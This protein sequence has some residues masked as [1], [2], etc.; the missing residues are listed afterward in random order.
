MPPLHINI[1]TSDYD[2]IRDIALGRVPIE[3][4]SIN[5][6]IYPIEETFYRFVHYREWDVS[7]MSF[8]KFA[9]IMSE[10]DPDI[11]GL[12]IFTARM[13]RQS[14]VYV[15]RGGG[16]ESGADLAGKRI[17]V[18]EWAQTAA[19]YTRGWLTDDLGIPLSD[20]Q[21]FQA[22][23]NEPGRREQISLSLPEGCNLTPVPDKSLKDMLQDG[24]LDAIFA[25][26]PPVGMDAPDCLIEP[27]FKDAPAE[28]AAY[29]EASGIFPI[30]HIMAIRRDVYEA[31][32]WLAQNL[33]KAFTQARE[34]SLARIF[35]RQTSRFM[36]PWIVEYA[37]Q[38]KAQLGK[39]YYPYGLE[40]N[41]HTLEVYLRWCFEQGIC[42]R[43]LT[44]DELFA[45][46][47]RTRFKV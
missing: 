2:H 23:L 33:L 31:N 8:G 19:I 25:A 38:K 4:A 47:T 1:A 34:M 39:D 20:V 29:F 13:F 17:G 30:M 10:D 9:S 37:E 15:R 28:E 46:E 18:P 11:I 3:G 32:R 7:E 35:D 21:W 5:Y 14:S 40:E 43:P 12:P 26:R 27:L 42:K 6:Q 16:I 22:G 45:P 24:E 36:V 44:P 41:R